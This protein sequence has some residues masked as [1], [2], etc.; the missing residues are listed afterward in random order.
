[1]YIRGSRIVNK[2]IANIMNPWEL[3]KKLTVIVTI[4]VLIFSFTIIG[5][6]EPFHL[7]ILAIGTIF[8]CHIII[9][10][11]EE[12][13]NSEIREKEEFIIELNYTYYEK[14]L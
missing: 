10:S 6:G 8:I 3:I 13:K 12:S 14:M 7:T 9:K 2:Q 1:M 11:K 5:E 4:V